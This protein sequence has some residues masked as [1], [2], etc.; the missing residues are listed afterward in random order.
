MARMDYEDAVMA[1]LEAMPSCGMCQQDG[2]RCEECVAG[3]TDGLTRTKIQWGWFGDEVWGVLR[4]ET[5][6]QMVMD[7]GYDDDYADKVWDY[8]LK[9]VPLM[10]YEDEKH[11][12]FTQEWAKEQNRQAHNWVRH[13][14]EEAGCE[15]IKESTPFASNIIIR[16]LIGYAMD[17]VPSY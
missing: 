14:L 17:K 7:L 5:T 16:A 1:K 13:A 11:R 12:P 4:K 2:M 8:L 9:D 3:A 6:C 10:P 15:G